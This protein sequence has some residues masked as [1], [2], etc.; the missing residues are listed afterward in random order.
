MNSTFLLCHYKCVS[1][2]T[3]AAVPVFRSPHTTIQRQKRGSLCPCV[4]LRA[5][6]PFSEGPQQMSFLCLIGQNW[7]MCLLGPVT[8][9]ENGIATTGLI[10][11]WGQPSLNLVATRS[12]ID[13]WKKLGEI[14][15]TPVTLVAPYIW[16]IPHIMSP[17]WKRNSPSWLAGRLGCRHVTWTPPTRYTCSRL[18]FR[19]EQRQ[20]LGASSF[21]FPMK[22][23]E[24]FG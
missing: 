12:K 3:V 15:R 18:E 24:P 10:E 7:V 9:K 16:E 1:P 23:G 19:T 2:G 6:K 21:F 8:M 17:R 14:L 13:N 11:I 5:K 22:M 20:E 4:S